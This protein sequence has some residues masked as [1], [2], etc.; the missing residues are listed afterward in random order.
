VLRAMKIPAG[1]HE[2]IFKFEPTVIKTGNT[3]TLIS[4]G[5]LFLIPLGWFFIEKRKKK[6]V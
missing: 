4:Y 1:K 3:I 2:I 6:H 5:L